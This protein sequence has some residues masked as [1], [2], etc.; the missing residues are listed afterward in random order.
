MP[1]YLVT[2]SREVEVSCRDED[3]AREAA[4]KVVETGSSEI[5]S[6]GETR[7]AAK[8]SGEPLVTGIREHDKEK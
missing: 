3:L 2:V 1:K 4:L 8:V 5:N 7:Y 6:Y